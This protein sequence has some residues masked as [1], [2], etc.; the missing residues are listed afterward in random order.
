MLGRHRAGWRTATAATAS[1]ILAAGSVAGA[2]AADE[3]AAPGGTAA[4]DWQQYAGD[5]IRVIATQ[6]PWQ[7]AIEPLIPAFE[8][9]TG[10]TVNFE[11]LPEEQFRQR[12]Q[13]ELTA[14]SADIDVFMSA[15]LQD[16][17][18]FSR[19]VW[20]EDLSSYPADPSLTSPEYGFE[21]FGQGLIEGHTIDGALIGIPILTDVEMLYYRKDRLE[22]AGVE[23]PTT[24]E[25][26]EAALAVLDDPENGVR[27]WGSRGRGA[28]AVTQMSTFLYNHGSDWTNDEGHAGF[29]TDEGIAAFDFYGRNLREHGPAG[30]AGFSWEEIMP[31]FQQGQLVFWNDSS[32]F[33]GQVT[34]PA[35]SVDVENIGFARMPAGPG[36]EYNAFFPWALSMSSLSQNKPQA[37]SFIQWATSQ[38][39]V[40]RLQESGVAGA[41]TDTSF[42]DTVP[43]EWVEVFQYDLE[44]ARPKLPVVV[45]VPEVRDA[46]GAAIVSSIEGGDVDAAVQQAAQEFDRAVDAAG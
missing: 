12:L 31:L 40:N 8:E 23:L 18:R 4:F 25:E 38:E 29:D 16:G 39:I 7:A 35:T 37:W 32:A 45:P 36:G 46:I 14:G 27:A 43:A 21:S 28:A 30:V 42:P 44:I 19:A 9:L 24:L 20:Y 2:L 13:V 22:E 26:F 33:L 15:V 34:D 17:A 1:L 11:S 41:R 3:S 10:I 6:N 5:E